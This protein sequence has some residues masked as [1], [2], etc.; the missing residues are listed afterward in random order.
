QEHLDVIDYHVLGN[1]FRRQLCSVHL[2]QL[3]SYYSLQR[4]LICRIKGIIDGLSMLRVL[5][6]KQFKY[7]ELL[8]LKPLVLIILFTLNCDGSVTSILEGHCTIYTRKSTS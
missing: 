6:V 1:L 5:S 2:I 8:V 3:L 4:M 7:L